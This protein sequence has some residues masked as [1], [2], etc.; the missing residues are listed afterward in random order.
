LLACLLASSTHHITS[1]YQYS[2][3]P[4]FLFP[5]PIPILTSPSNP[6][7]LPPPNPPLSPQSMKEAES[8]D[9][10]PFQGTTSIG[11]G[12]LS[13]RSC[14][15]A[16]IFLSLSSHA[17]HTPPPKT[18]VCLL[19]PSVGEEMISPATITELLAEELELELEW[20]LV[21]ERRRGSSESLDLGA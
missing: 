13:P 14:S 3:T 20:V 8:R 18:R 12:S 11:G 6:P 10:S 9:H 1:R 5:P 19:Q 21:Y 7:L 17:L 15:Q 16:L 4:P 2:Y